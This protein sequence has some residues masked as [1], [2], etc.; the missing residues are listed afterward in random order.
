[1]DLQARLI[2]TTLMIV[3]GLGLTHAIAAE[4]VPSKTAQ[5][6]DVCRQAGSEYTKLYNIEEQGRVITICQKGDKYYYINTA[7]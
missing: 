5:Q 2:S 3:A 7:K 1:M 4:P 6:V